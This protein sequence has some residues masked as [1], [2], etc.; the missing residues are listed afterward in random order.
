MPFKPR[1]PPLIKWYKLGS[2]LYGPHRVLRSY[3][4]WV[5]RAALNSPMW[6]QIFQKVRARSS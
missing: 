2:I 1:T 6:C 4:P 5:D 3:V